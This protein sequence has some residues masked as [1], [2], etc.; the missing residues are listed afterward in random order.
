MT[1]VKLCHLDELEEGAATRF[2]V[3]G[4]RLAVARIG[5]DV[6]C[7]ADRCSHEDFSLS[8]GEVLPAECEIECARHGATFDLKT[9]AAMSLPATKAVETYV[10]A[11]HDGVV[12]VELP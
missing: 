6:Y 5:D 2:D 8:E 3:E 4:A 10:V 11:I 7:V 9:G 12:E 1:S